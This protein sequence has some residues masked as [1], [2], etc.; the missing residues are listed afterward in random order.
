MSRSYK[1]IVKL[2]ELMDIVFENVQTN[3]KL[4]DVK[5]FPTK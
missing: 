1:N 3:V 2:K 5:V 4:S